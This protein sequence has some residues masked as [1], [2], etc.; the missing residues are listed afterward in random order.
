MYKTKTEQVYFTDKSFPSESPWQQI[1]NNNSDVEKY[2][3]Q[4]KHQTLVATKTQTQRNLIVAAN[5]VCK[6]CHT[7]IAHW[8]KI[9][10]TFHLS[11]RSNLRLGLCLSNM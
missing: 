5:P 4:F 6:I 8:P 11:L 3:G 7:P 1:Q 9:Q 10:A 2:I